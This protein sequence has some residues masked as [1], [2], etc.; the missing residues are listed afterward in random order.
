MSGGIG[1]TGIAV[2]LADTQGNLLFIGKVAREPNSRW[3][4]TG[5]I[6]EFWTYR[7]KGERDNGIDRHTMQVMWGTRVVN[8]T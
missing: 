5:H 6:G 4:P 3:L 1:G 2:L 8:P 7:L